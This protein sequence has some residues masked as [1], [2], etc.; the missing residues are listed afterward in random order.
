MT[1]PFKIIVKNYSI[2]DTS[3]IGCVWHA[4]C[5]VYCWNEGVPGLSMVPNC[6]HY[7]LRYNLNRCIAQ[8]CS[9]SGSN[10]QQTGLAQKDLPVV[11]S[12]AMALIAMRDFH[13]VSSK[14][15]CIN[16][17]ERKYVYEFPQR[18]C[19]L[20]LS[21]KE[22]RHSLSSHCSYLALIDARY[23]IFRHPFLRHLAFPY[24]W[25]DSI[26][27]FYAHFKHVEV[28]WCEVSWGY[29]A[30][31]EIYDL[32]KVVPFFWTTRYIYI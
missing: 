1:A 24:F 30:L 9:C 12:I 10:V 26:E 31:I 13:R 11:V 23:W 2:V 28:V 15:S 4:L 19:E 20:N 22:L 7:Y 27:I 21:V 17:L 32:L 5:M 14:K 16:D 29:A 3:N 18:K 6:H 25:S 8:L